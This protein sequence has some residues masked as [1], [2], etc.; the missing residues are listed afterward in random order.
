MGQGVVHEDEFAEG[1]LFTEM[2]VQAEARDFRLVAMPEM[3]QF[4]L[5]T[6]AASPGE[7]VRE[8][9]GGIATALPHMAYKAIGMNFHWRAEV[10]EGIDFAAEVHRMFVPQ[11]S[12]LYNLFEQGGARFGGYMSKDVFGVRLKLDVKPVKRE[13]DGR[14]VE[15]LVYQFNFHLDL[16]QDDPL[17][18]IQGALERW[19]D[20]EELA[21][22]MFMTTTEWCEG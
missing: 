14:L 19:E 13:A 5:K 8:R 12:P 16:D 6:S 10:E 17:L 22:E 15:G 2:A 3:I 1:S 7:L 11:H 9:V 18:G 21:K 4:A 20:A